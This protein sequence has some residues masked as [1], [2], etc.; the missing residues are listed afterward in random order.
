MRRSW[1]IIAIGLAIVAGLTA[2]GGG[3]KSDETVNPPKAADGGGTVNVEAIYKSNCVTCHGADLAGGSGPS[4]QKVGA[5]LSKD[6]IA[7]KIANGGAGMPP[8]NNT[9]KDNEIAALAE[10]LSTKK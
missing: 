5:R 8:Y 10:W 2:C 4:L 3:S 6:Q 7:A 1:G 9:L